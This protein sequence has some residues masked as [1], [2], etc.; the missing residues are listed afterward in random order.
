MSRSTD[1]SFSPAL[2][3][4]GAPDRSRRTSTLAFVPLSFDANRSP[5]PRALPSRSATAKQSVPRPTAKQSA[6]PRV[7]SDREATESPAPRPSFE[8]PSAPEIETERLGSRTLMG[9][10]TPGADAVT[11]VAPM[12]PRTVVLVQHSWAQL[13]PVSDV[14]A[15]LF[16]DRLFELDPTLRRLC[17]GNLGDQKKD[18]VQMIA[19]VVG[20]LNNP[21][22]LITALQ[23]FGARHA[24]EAPERTYDLIGEALMWSLR[25]ALRDGFTKEIEEA[26]TRVY[27]LVSSVTKQAA[28][29]DAQVAPTQQLL[30]GPIMSEQ[31]TLH[32]EARSLSQDW[33]RLGATARGSP[34]GLGTGALVALLCVVSSV[35]STLLLALMSSRAEGALSAATL[36]GVPFL[37]VVLV[38]V[39]FGLGRLSARGGGG[40][41]GDRGWLRRSLLK[42]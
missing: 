20:G 3:T 5:T 30:H 29:G 28:A 39:A 11:E 24:G 18:L 36:Y 8:A 19:V 9:M 17:R 10:P 41:G 42:N 32:E 13:V 34:S 6:I 12:S 16:Y 22:K 4:S 27:T 35:G 33:E 2:P 14:V 15:A 21:E 38:F 25:E 1:P 26:W 40:G 31:R 37:L 23:T 7:N